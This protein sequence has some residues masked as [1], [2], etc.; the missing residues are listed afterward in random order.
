V[1]DL[2]LLT[3][4]EAAQLLRLSESALNKLRYDGKIAFVRLGAK[5][6]Y[7]RDQLEKFVSDQQFIYTQKETK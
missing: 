6:F 7:T 3:T 4:K 2:G 5:V 1:S